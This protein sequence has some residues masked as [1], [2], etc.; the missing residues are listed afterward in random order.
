M[1]LVAV[2]NARFAGGGMMLSP[3]AE[4]DD[5]KLDVVTA[6]GLNRAAILR[7]LTRIH[8]GGHVANP[9]VKTV[10]GRHVTIQTFAPE[11]ALRIEVDGNVSGHT[12]ASYTII[13]RILRMV[14]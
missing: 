5:G 8:K 14:V 7:E 10:Q 3:Q 11:D 12:P 6:S 2:A 1:N 9:R 13:P 4:I